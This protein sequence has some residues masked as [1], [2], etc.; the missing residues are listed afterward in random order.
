MSPPLRVLIVDDEPLAVDRM[1][2]LL[3]RLD[4]IEVIATTNTGQHALSAAQEHAPDLCFLDIGMPQMDGISVARALALMPQPPKVVFVTAFDSFA[5]AAFD[6]DA[7]DYLVKPVE[8]SRLERA[9][10]KVRL[11]TDAPRPTL[12]PT[13]YIKEFWASDRQGLIRVAVEDIHRI[14]AERDYMRLHAGKRSWLI[15]DSLSRLEEQL[16][17]DL[18]VRLH[19]SAIVRRAFILGLRYDERWIACLA[20]GSEQTVGR[21]YA[22]N[23]RKMASRTRGKP[24]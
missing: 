15:N 3:A 18:F 13:R 23:A 4:G 17:P 11:Q 22:D 16:D 8:P 21:A 12:E 10:A 19:R 24:V 20:D 2:V 1:L 6:V 5:V 14:S 7:I 9:V